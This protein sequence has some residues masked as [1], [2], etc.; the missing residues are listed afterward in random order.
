[1]ENINLENM[2]VKEIKAFPEKGDAFISLLLKDKRAGV[3][4]YGEQ[5]KRQAQRDLKI[6]EE[7]EKKRKV[8]KDLYDLGY[9][10]ICGLDEV[11]RGPLAG[12]VVTAAVIMPK[13]SIIPGID[14]SKKLSKIK[15]EKL[16]EEIK[17]QAISYSF[18]VISPQR[19]DEIN[20]LN[21]T[22]K[23]MISSITR[24]NPKPEILLIDA[25]NLNTEIEELSFV[26]GDSLVYSIGAASIIAKV[27]RDNYMKKMSK[28]YPQYGFD[29]NSGYGT[30]E[31]IEAIRKYGLSPIHRKTFCKSFLN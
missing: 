20:I 21:A 25:L 10:F 19:I 15:R 12:P 1:M 5:L 6:L 11:G 27:E 22:K 8:E 17:K 3:R 18:G 26:K 14:D 4:K 29:H 28:R 2:T 23:A 24:L 13:D 7:T 30:K 16:A 9:E 31:H